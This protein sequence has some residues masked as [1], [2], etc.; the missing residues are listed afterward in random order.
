MFAEEEQTLYGTRESVPS[1]SSPPELDRSELSAPTPWRLLPWLISGRTGVVL[2]AIRG[3]NVYAAPQDV[4]LRSMLHE[5]ARALVPTNLAM[6]LQDRG[7]G[8]P[9]TPLPGTSVNKGRRTAGVWRPGPPLT[10]GCCPSETRLRRCPLLADSE[11]LEVHRC[12]G[13]VDYRGV[14]LLGDVAVFGLRGDS[15]GV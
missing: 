3:P 6:A 11:H 7:Y 9:R 10:L 13:K 14:P 1:R 5:T 15:R 12:S 2:G 4:V 8:L